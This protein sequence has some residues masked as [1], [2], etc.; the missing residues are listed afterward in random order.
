MHR[1]LVL[2][3]FLPIAVSCGVQAA[4][5][6]ASSNSLRQVALGLANYHDSFQAAPGGSSATAQPSTESSTQQATADRKIIY[7][8]S[9][10]LH[11]KAF[12]ET[13]R[14]I[15]VLV[16]DSGGYVSQ[17][18]EDRAYGAQRGGRW[19]IRVPIAS[20]TRLLDEVAQL[21]VAERREVQSQDVT[22]E[23][24][25]LGSRLK[26]KQTL[27]NRLLE[28]MSKRG[29]EIT[30]VLA[31][32]NELSRVRE[33]I[34]KLQGRLN[35]LS[36]RV[37]LTTIEIQA[38]ERLDYQPPEAT[39]GQRIASTFSV[40]LDRLRQFG[41]AVVLMATALAPWLVA[42]LIVLLPIGMVVRKRWRPLL[43]TA[44]A[45]TA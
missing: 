26:N 10:H 20:F 6:A 42:A 8:A 35:Y 3:L 1:L 18:S 2:M 11:V 4:R 12:A 36:D 25:D 43:S 38:Y 7:R 40:S 24:V 15:T 19:T 13:D 31:L 27:E 22:E 32:E 44:T 16:S 21:G 14:Q 37:A 9:L 34:E 23:F 5:D 29:D 45:T 33:E 17:F 30:D 41:E 39:F 28:L